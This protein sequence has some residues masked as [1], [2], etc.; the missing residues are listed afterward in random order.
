MT[1]DEFC[2]TWKVTKKEREKLKCYLI[3]LRIEQLM[4][5]L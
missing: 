5:E 2:K 4:R 1:F 3:V